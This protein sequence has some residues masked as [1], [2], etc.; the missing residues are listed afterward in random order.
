M[1]GEGKLAGVACS[2]SL[3]PRFVNNDYAPAEI[4]IALCMRHEALAWS[5]VAVRSTQR[6]PHLG[7]P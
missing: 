6:K 2:G 1:R 5:G 4:V 3:A 7:K